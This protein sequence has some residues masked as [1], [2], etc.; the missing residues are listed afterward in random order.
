MHKI[1]DKE[2]RENA[3]MTFWALDRVATMHLA[4]SP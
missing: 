4:L 3:A 1:M 2:N